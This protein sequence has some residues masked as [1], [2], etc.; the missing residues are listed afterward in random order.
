MEETCSPMME[1]LNNVEEELRNLFDRMK[2]PG[3][4]ET[5]EFFDKQ[6][7]ILLVKRDE[8]FEKINA[9]QKDWDIF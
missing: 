2:K 5:E 1:E 4:N 9:C 3:E 7:K 6:E 8:I